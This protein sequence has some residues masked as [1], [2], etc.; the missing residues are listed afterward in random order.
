MCS[1]AA[2]AFSAAV[3]LEG[4]SLY[5]WGTG[6]FGEFQ[7]PH[8]VKKIDKPVLQVSIGSDFGA[9]LTVGGEVFTWGDNPQ[10]QLGTGDFVNC[11]TPRPLQKLGKEGRRFTSLACGSNFTLCLSQADSVSK[12][13][14]QSSL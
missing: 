10:G 1:I 5:L 3:S 2:G 6:T 12:K 13:M 11:G 9:A 14:Q 8:L 4:N 7:T